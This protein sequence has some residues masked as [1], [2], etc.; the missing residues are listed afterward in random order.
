[1][2][3]LYSD[4]QN[5]ESLTEKYFGLSITRFLVASLIVVV[6]G[7][8]LGVLLFGTNSLEVLMNVDDYSNTLQTKIVQLK[9]ENAKE[10]KVYFELKEISAQ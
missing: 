5:K 9:K 7:I 10:Q 2:S 1:M 8:Y 6:V 4:I 3:D